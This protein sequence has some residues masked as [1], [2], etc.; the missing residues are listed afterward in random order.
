MGSSASINNNLKKQDEIIKKTINKNS[1]IKVIDI[2]KYL[3]DWAYVENILLHKDG[4][5]K[6]LIKIKDFIVVNDLK[7][8]R[9]NIQPNNFSGLYFSK[10]GRVIL[11]RQNNKMYT[12]LLVTLTYDGNISFGKYIVIDFNENL[13]FNDLITNTFMQN[14]IS[15]TIEQSDKSFSEEIF[16]ILRNN[17]FKLEHNQKLHLVYMFMKIIGKCVVKNGINKKFSSNEDFNSK[18]LALST[19]ILGTNSEITILDNYYQINN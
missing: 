11:Y 16:C 6:F 2:I 17:P 15:E 9:K 18:D 5:I 13:F 14:V 10:S 1:R 19:H 8:I 7:N 4:K 12:P 3:E